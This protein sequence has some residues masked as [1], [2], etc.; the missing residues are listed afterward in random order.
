MNTSQENNLLHEI[1]NMVYTYRRSTRLGYEIRWDEI[2]DMHKM[3][4]VAALIDCDDRD[5]FCIYENKNY[6][7]FIS[8][9]F[10]LLKKDDVSARRGFIECVQ[11][12]LIDYYKDRIMQLLEERLI[13]IYES[14]SND[15][16]ITE[17]DCGLEYCVY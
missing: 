11:T 13:F 17:N 14:D 16:F 15:C 10:L 8:T 4:A 9:L 7:E 6:E 12:N 2:S 1:D 3:K 5:L